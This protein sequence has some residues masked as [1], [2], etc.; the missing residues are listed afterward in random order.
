MT[1]GVH[2]GSVEALQHFRGTLAHMELGVAD[3]FAAAEHHASLVLDALD[4]LIARTL[5]Q[6][7]ANDED[8][9]GTEDHAAAAQAAQ[10][11]AR[12]EELAALRRLLTLAMD[13]FQD[14]RLSITVRMTDAVERASAFL[15]GRAEALGEYT[16][17]SPVGTVSPGMRGGLA[18]FFPWTAPEIGWPMRG[19]IEELP[20]F[21]GFRGVSFPTLGTGVSHL[22]TTGATGVSPGWAYR[23]GNRMLL[24]F[25]TVSPAGALPW[26]GTA[27]SPTTSFLNLELS[28]SGKWVR[29]LGIGT[30][31]AP[32]YDLKMSTS[33]LS[34]GPSAFE[35][36]PS[37]S[38]SS[39][40]SSPSLASGGGSFAPCG[41][42]GGYDFGGGMG[43]VGG[44]GGGCA[45]G[46]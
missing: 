29:P 20:S 43:G 2:V 36:A 14:R 4:A 13:T 11:Q 42:F 26:L 10:A 15:A 41:S 45:L 18:T 19:P 32:S 3:C 40:G 28:T 37:L 27:P 44:F 9:G 22:S 6:A 24:G 23:E 35:Y 5:R 25:S 7:S 17:V 16:P 21:S 30:A 31:P 33:A 39:G 1:N 34:V 38:I 46:S 8:R 12:M